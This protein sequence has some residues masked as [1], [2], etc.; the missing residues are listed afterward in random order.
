[1]NSSLTKPRRG[2]TLVEVIVAG[3]LIG[4]VMSVALPT[5]GW[6]GQQRRASL[7]RQEAIAEVA[8]IMERITV[9]PWERITTENVRTI[10]LADDTERQLPE[11]KLTIAVSSKPP[12]PDAKRIAVELTW[13]NRAGRRVA[14][15]RLV[16]WVYRSGRAK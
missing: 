11:A 2:M 15:V 1:M 8:N 14:P 16:A 5:L 3:V 12:A 9:E 4:T 13:K 10:K 7:E 6:I